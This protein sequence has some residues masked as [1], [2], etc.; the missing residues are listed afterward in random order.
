MDSFRMKVREARLRAL[1]PTTTELARR[2]GVPRPTVS[3]IENGARLPSLA[4][5]LRLS[6]ALGCTVNDLVEPVQ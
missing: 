6:A 2:S 4:C 3:A 5:A 1:I